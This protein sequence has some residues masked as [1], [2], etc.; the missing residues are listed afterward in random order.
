MVACSFFH[1]YD[2]AIWLR[3]KLRCVPYV[4]QCTMAKLY[5]RHDV[6]T[7]TMLSVSHKANASVNY[8]CTTF[9]VLGVSQHNV[10]KV[11]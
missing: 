4:Q 3:G 2:L 1:N 7:K 9:S 6:F 5:L 8:A 11:L 10:G